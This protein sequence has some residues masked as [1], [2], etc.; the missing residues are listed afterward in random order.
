MRKWIRKILTSID[1]FITQASS[2]FYI[3]ILLLMIFISTQAV[4][5]CIVYFQLLNSEEITNFA[6][7]YINIWEILPSK[8]LTN[9]IVF[10]NKNIVKTKIEFLMNM[11]IALSGL[12]LSM[13]TLASYLKKRSVERKVSCFKKNEVINSGKDDVD[14]M[15][16]YYENADFVSISSTSFEWLKNNQKA[17]DILENL[18]K[19]G[20]LNLFTSGEITHVKKCFDDCTNMKNSLKKSNAS[21]RFSYIERDNAKYVLY[22]QEK[23]GHTYII[24]VHENHESQYLIQVISQ[25]VNK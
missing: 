25:L 1:N 15:C 11:S 4:A 14:I 3:I 24:Q 7:R 13:I 10:Q 12:L 19:Y 16:Q 5:F 23:D 22:R 21:L 20:K 18:A 2:L 9:D 6:F 8:D 17:K